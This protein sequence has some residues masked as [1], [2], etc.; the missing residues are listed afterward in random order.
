VIVSAVQKCAAVKGSK[1][2]IAFTPIGVLS[3]AF[4]SCF[5]DEKEKVSNTLEVQ[6]TA[7]NHQQNWYTNSA[8]M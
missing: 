1:I 4:V 7:Q 5:S 8:E 2:E 6:K 3:N